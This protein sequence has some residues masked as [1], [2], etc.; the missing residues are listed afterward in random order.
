MYF[1][2]QL[3]ITFVVI[4][5][6]LIMLFYRKLLLKLSLFSLCDSYI[7]IFNK[8]LS[9][10]LLDKKSCSINVIKSSRLMRWR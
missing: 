4:L 3:Y 9:F 10:S 8:H 1:I 5:M 7:Y 2:I 6:L